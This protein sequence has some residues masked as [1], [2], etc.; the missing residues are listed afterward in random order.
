MTLK[1][2]LLT[3][4]LFLSACGD[5]AIRERVEDLD[6]AIDNYAYA[7]RWSRSKDAVA[8]HMN[9]DG[10][11]PSIDASVM[12]QIRVTGFTLTEKTLAPDHTEATV[13]GVLNYYYNNGVTLR[14][15]EYAQSWWYQEETGK[16]YIDSEFPQFK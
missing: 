1:I 6:Y 4:M 5:V 13:K 2:R 10:T 14:T 3:L 8:Y 15:V 12:E 9:R 11:R 16:W 7:L